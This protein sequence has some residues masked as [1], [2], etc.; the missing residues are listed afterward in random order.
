MNETHF[1]VMTLPSLLL[2][3]VH[4]CANTRK[5]CFHTYRATQTL[6]PVSVEYS[7]CEKLKF[8]IKWIKQYTNLGELH[9]HIS[10]LCHQLL[11]P[12]ITTSVDRYTQRQQFKYTLLCSSS[13]FLFA[14]SHPQCTFIFIGK[15][16]VPRT[17]TNTQCVVEKMQQ[18]DQ[19]RWMLLWRL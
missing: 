6:Y 11:L 17:K 19:G 10:F 9:T 14:C 12:I 4:R 15:S 16:G 2:F 8:K 18:V 3:I 13:A 1:E 7:M 5:W